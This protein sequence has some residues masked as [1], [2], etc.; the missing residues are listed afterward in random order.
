MY[1]RIIYSYIHYSASSFFQEPKG[2]TTLH[3]IIMVFTPPV[4]RRKRQWDVS[5]LQPY[6]EA[7]EETW[8]TQDT[9]GRFDSTFLK[10][11]KETD[12]LCLSQVIGSER[13]IFLKGILDNLW[14]I[15]NATA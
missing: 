2:F 11:C 5:F 8:S 3:H 4:E 12:D 1:A 10:I 14:M 13:W 7:L 9:N 6:C 15:F